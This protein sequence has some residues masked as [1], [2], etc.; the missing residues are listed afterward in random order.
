MHEREPE[1]RKTAGTPESAVKFCDGLGFPKDLMYCDPEASALQA[2]TAKRAGR[3]V[4]TG[5]CA[6]ME[7]Y[8]ALDLKAGLGPTFFSIASPKVGALSQSCHLQSPQLLL[9]PASS[10][11]QAIFRQGLGVLREATKNYD[12]SL[13]KPPRNEMAFQQVGMLPALPV[14]TSCGEESRVWRLRTGRL[15][16]L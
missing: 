3:Q 5:V 6:Q 7:S 14:A 9:S 10:W 2:A 1:Q 16:R 4:T 15:V 11:L 13:T 8:K 12:T